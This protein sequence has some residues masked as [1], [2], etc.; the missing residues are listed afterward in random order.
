MKWE[1]ADLLSKQA[2]NDIL[3]TSFTFKD[4]IPK[5]ID[6]SQKQSNFIL[7]TAIDEFEVFW[8]IEAKCQENH[9]EYTKIKLLWSTEKIFG[10]ILV[11]GHSSGSGQLSRVFNTSENSSSFEFDNFQIRDNEA[12]ETVLY[13]CHC[14]NVN[15]KED[16]NVVF[17]VKNEEIAAN[18]QV[19][20]A[21]N[22]AFAQI[23]A[24]NGSRV[25]IEDVE[26]SIFK[27]I[28]KFV[29]TGTLEVRHSDHIDV[30]RG[31]LVAAE[32]FH[33]KSLVEVLQN[34]IPDIA[35]QMSLLQVNE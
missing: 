33:V 17:V 24:K 7:I 4:F 35:T 10:H 1:K 5:D 28:L 3:I 30:I 11:K 8:L 6:F 23:L 13:I 22:D 32:K 12:V 25:V 2:L 29:T 21:Y 15:F 19:L 27:I 34:F 9:L 20:S 26:P 14:M 16:L 18:G 31:V